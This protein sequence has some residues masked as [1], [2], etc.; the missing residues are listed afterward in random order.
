[1]I[2][3]KVSLWNSAY[4]IKNIKSRNKGGTV[5]KGKEL[6]HSRISCLE[7][8]FYPVLTMNC[9]CS[10]SSADLSVQYFLDNV[11]HAPTVLLSH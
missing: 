5:R 11:L 3:L 9:I 8:K 1:M 6:V 4:Q 2:F 10:Y 7:S